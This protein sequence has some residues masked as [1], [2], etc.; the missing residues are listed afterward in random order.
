MTLILLIFSKVYL[1]AITGHVPQEMVQA[2]SA[3]IDICYLARRSDLTEAT[4]K[5]FDVAL[6]KFYEYRE[7]FRTTGVRPKGSWLSF[8]LPINTAQIIFNPALGHSAHSRCMH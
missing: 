6:A 8:A 2:I 7:V 4:L 5:L 3:F 1:S